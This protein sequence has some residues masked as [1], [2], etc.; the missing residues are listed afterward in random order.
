MTIII[1]TTAVADLDNEDTWFCHKAFV[2]LMITGAAI[3]LEPL[4]RSTH[5]NFSNIKQDM[6][7][8]DFLKQMPSDFI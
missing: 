3:G 4:T 2:F 1:K 8:H 5:L 7:L 6:T